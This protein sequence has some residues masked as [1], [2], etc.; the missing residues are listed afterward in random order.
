ML[1]F[2]TELNAL[3]ALETT[4]PPDSELAELLFAGR[5]LLEAWDRKQTDLSLQVEEI[6]DLLK[7]ADTSLTQEALDAEKARGDK[8][9]RLAIGLCDVLEDFY[10]YARQSEN[11]SLAHDAALMW[12]NAGD[13]LETCG[14]TRIGEEGQFL[15]PAIHTVKA[16]AVS[17]LPREY[18]ARVLGS[19]YRYLGAV[20]RKAS[21]IVSA[22]N[23]EGD[24]ECVKS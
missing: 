1:D 15:D 11:K 8:L 2:E 12:K 19:G 21:V 22:G 3:L 17:P 18:V 9:L 20:A 6:Y 14:I 13:L 16:A 10:S 7:D 4:S 5:T 23:E 24:E